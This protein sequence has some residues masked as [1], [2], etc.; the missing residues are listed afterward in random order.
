MCLLGQSLLPELACFLW[1][2]VPLV[3]QKHR[4]KGSRSVP[5]G[6]IR[7]KRHFS[8][9]SAGVFALETIEKGRFLCEYAGQRISAGDAAS[10]TCRKSPAGSCAKLFEAEHNYILVFKEHFSD[11]RSVCT[12]LDPTHVGNVGRFI[13]HSCGPNLDAF[14]VR[15]GACP[16][17]RVAFF[18]ARDVCVGDELTFSYHEHESSLFQEDDSARKPCF[19]GHTDCK[20]WCV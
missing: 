6:R 15:V 7:S 5:I 10:R 17:P 16:H 4:R 12:C 1:A 8:C 18:A 20:K 13:N 9:P 19:C 2:E 3:G 11:G 14:A